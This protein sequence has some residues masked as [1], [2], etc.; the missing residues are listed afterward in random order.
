MVNEQKYQAILDDYLSHVEKVV[1][2]FEREIEEQTEKLRQ[3]A[4]DNGKELPEDGEKKAQ[5]N[6]PSR[7]SHRGRGGKGGPGIFDD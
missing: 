3:M 5:E 6:R 2:E 4:S 7:G 1:G